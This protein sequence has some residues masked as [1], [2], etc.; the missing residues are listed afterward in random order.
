VTKLMNEIDW[1][2]NDEGNEVAHKLGTVLVV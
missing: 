2:A 1:C